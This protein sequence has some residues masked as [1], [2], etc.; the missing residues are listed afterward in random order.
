MMSLRPVWGTAG[1][2][3]VQANATGV[4]AGLGPAGWGQH[5]RG[6]AVEGPQGGGRRGVAFR[7]LRKNSI[8]GA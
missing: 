3:T 5:V 7:K 8:T 6:R 4:R 1:S 2:P